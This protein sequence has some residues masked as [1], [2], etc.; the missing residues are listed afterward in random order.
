[1]VTISQ[2]EVKE[3]IS[4]ENGQKLGQLTDLEINVDQGRITAIVLGN[5]GKMMGMMSKNEEL[6]VPWSDILTIGEDVILV[7]KSPNPALHPPNS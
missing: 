4:V 5:K 2:L 6:V 3:V 7:K 1:M